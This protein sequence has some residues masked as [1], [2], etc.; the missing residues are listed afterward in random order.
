MLRPIHVH[1][2]KC[3]GTSIRN[4]LGL[5]ADP[6]HFTAA[7]LRAHMGDAEWEAG[8]PFAVVRNPWERFWSLY[9]YLSRKDRGEAHIRWVELGLS[10]DQWLRLLLDGAE[11][12]RYAFQPR[13]AASQSSW[14]ADAPEVIVYN[15]EDFPEKGWPNLLARLG[16]TLQPLAHANSSVAIGLRGGYSTGLWDEVGERYAEDIQAFGYTREAQDP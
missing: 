1:I 9:R 7:E 15:F 12:P 14:F 5:E 4:T 11:A 16:R 6:I 8:V 2:H 3:A 10:F 13:W